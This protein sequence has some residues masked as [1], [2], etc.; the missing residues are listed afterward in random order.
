ML[1]DISETPYRSWSTQSATKTVLHSSAIRSAYRH[2]ALN[3]LV[4]L[5]TLSFLSPLDLFER[6]LND[7]SSDMKRSRESW[8]RSS[9][10]EIVLGLIFRKLLP[11][12]ISNTKA[13]GLAAVIANV[14]SEA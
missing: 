6:P 9:Q 12:G 2:V 10:V 14:D 13:T 8:D 5:V 4:L 1:C 7:D 11:P 3:L